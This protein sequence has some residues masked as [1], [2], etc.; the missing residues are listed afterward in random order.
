MMQSAR[1]DRATSPFI[2]AAA[3]LVVGMVTGVLPKPLYV[4]GA[5][6]GL[7]FLVVALLSPAV[8]VTVFVLLTFLSQISAVGATVS[9]AKGAGAVL[10]LGWLY[11][12]RVVERRPWSED[13][14]RFA[15]LAAAFLV[16]GIASALWASDPHAALTST[17]RLAQ[18]PLL[19]LVIAS[20]VR[21]V[22]HLRMV[23]YA[24]VVGAAAAA[25]GGMAGLT[26]TDAVIA[27][28]GRLSGGILDPNYL[29]AVLVPS[30]VL[31]LFLALTAPSRLAKAAIGAAGAVATIGVFLTQSRGGVIA[32]AVASVGSIVAAGRFRGQVVGVLSFVAAF[33][34]IYL[35]LFAPPQSLS[36]ITAFT[37]NDSNRTN[38]WAVAETTFKQHPLAGIGAGNFTVVEKNY[39]VNLNQDLPRADL[40]VQVQQPVHNTYLQVASELG[41]VGLVLFLALLWV[42]IRACYRAA[43][44]ATAPA[45]EAVGR[46]VVIG[47]IGML[48]AF[49]FLTAQYEKQLWLVIALLLAY[50]G[51]A[52]QTA[53]ERA[54]RGTETRLASLRPAVSLAHARHLS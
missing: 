26:Q 39:V 43:V 21:S 31:S 35:L 48:V 18:G 50:A 46:A 13:V 54:T 17:L 33:A 30:V 45:V 49:V 2:L 29:A 24:F 28:S 3:V 52:S 36:R 53:E 10:V 9:V 19:V 11:H 7:G 27:S 8:A 41:L 20:A 15:I 42:P 1:L 14:R 47:S 40:I 32:L 25:L 23:C 44:R 6:F 4:A 12:E 34:A 37:A 16:W 22:R 51:A 38:L 5:V